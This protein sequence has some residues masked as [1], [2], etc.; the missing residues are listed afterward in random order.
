MSDSE[1]LTELKRLAEACPEDNCHIWVSLKWGQPL[2]FTSYVANRDS[3]PSV[4]AH[5]GDSPK[6]VID[7]ILPKVMGKRGN[8]QNIALKQME[9]AKLKAEVAKLESEI[10]P[11]LGAVVQAQKVEVVP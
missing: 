10:D 2:K 9:I 11:L 4:F 7:E 5:D 6:A 3:H 8:L 1:I